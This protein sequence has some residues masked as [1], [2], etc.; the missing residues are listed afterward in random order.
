ML[1]IFII[2]FSKPAVTKFAA[3]EKTK[4]VRAKVNL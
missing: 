4:N 3:Y 2:V 1:E